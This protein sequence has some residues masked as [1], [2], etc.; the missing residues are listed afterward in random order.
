M[1]KR[2]PPSLAKIASAFSSGHACA[3]A[4]VVRSAKHD[5]VGGLDA[6]K[7]PTTDQNSS[8]DPTGTGLDLISGSL[9]EPGTHCPNFEPVKRTV[10]RTERRK[11]VPLSG[12]AIREL[13][14][15]ANFPPPFYLTPRCL[16]VTICGAD[17]TAT[18]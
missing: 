17:R 9:R 18:R 13:D 11:T 14:N 3:S 8:E 4:V 15:E 16:I 12:T 6:T 1:F 2:A 7:M 5:P 10:R